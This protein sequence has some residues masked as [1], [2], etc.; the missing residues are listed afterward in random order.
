MSALEALD[1]ERPQRTPPHDVVAEQSVLGGMMIS[2]AAALTA[3]GLLEPRDFY[4]PK[5]QLIFEA[6]RKLTAAGDPTDVV[7]VSDELI[8]TGEL[9]RAGGADYLH[10]LTSIV[11]TA[12][13]AG[14]YAGIVSERALL[15]RLVDAGTRIV[16]MG[17]AGEG[18]PLAIVEAARGE[19]DNVGSLESH[20]HAASV[21]DQFDYWAE[22][23]QHPP[24]S[25]ETPWRDL[26]AML[27]GGL[28]DGR[29]Y[30]VGARPGD[31]KSIMALQ[32]AHRL[33]ME[34]PVA[35]SSLEM[36]R[37]ELLT[38]LVSMRAKIHMTTLAEHRL[39]RDQWIRVADVRR[40]VSELPLV[41]DDR[42]GVTVTSIQAFARTVAR[43]GHLAGV[44]V[45]YLQLVS[46]SR[47]KDRHEVVGEISR[48]L[49][50]MARD[51]NCPV[52]ALSQLNRDSVGKGRRAP[53]L[54]DLRESGSIEQDADVVLLLQ[55]A[56]D[57]DDQPGDRLNVHV[58]KN[59]HG[60]TGVR[61]L[62]WEGKFSRVVSPAWGF[63][64]DLVDASD[65][66]I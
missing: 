9:P 50:I 11:P 4:V 5:H 36:S 14:Y 37:N 58:A 27:G 13:N 31:G 33:A 6:I 18:E 28:H 44:V 24:G 46:G 62:L 32:I 65:R 52:V 16:E 25:V 49:K 20:Q 54:A 47:T 61:T 29:F 10:S 21:G 1:Y 45:D 15:R 63:V 56:L 19:V 41:I 30:V 7:A 53:S 8:K 12:A 22:A 3:L 38:R 42:S 17:Y 60:Q 40:E 66:G 23:Q 2:S 51:L 57:K 43:R 34:G 35:F 48:Q 64:P 59:R 39:S 26:N 55:R